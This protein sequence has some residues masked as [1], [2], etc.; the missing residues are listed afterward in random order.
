MAKLGVAGHSIDVGP[1]RAESTGGVLSVTD[2]VCEAWE[3]L[4]Q[5]SVAVQVR[6]VLY[7]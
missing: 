3:E 1:G 5:S 4:P 2:I 6:V 7:S